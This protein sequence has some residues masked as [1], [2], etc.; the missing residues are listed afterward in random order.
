MAAARKREQVAWEWWITTAEGANKTLIARR[1]AGEN[2]LMHVISAYRFVR[3]TWKWLVIV[4]IAVTIPDR[5]NVGCCW[6]TGMIS[7]VNG[8]LNQNRVCK[9]LVFSS[10]GFST[11]GNKLP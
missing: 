7:A 10:R 3:R 8:T 5:K 9:T 2:Q 11:S 4:G 6:R 1:K